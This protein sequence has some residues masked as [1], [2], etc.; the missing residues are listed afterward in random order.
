VVLLPLHTAILKPDFD[1]SL[2]QDQAMSD[3][4]PS[5]SR[6]VPIVVEFLLQLEYLVP[7]VCGSLSFWL[8]A[9][10][11][12]AIRCKKEMNVMVY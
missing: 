3:L 2:G 6:Q 8:H 11:I 1:L 4:D 9:R 5:S 10:L 7:R 12:R